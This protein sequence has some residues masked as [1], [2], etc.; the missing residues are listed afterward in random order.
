[1]GFL[2]IPSIF[3]RVYVVVAPVYSAYEGN[4]YGDGSGCT[5]RIG[6]SKVLILGK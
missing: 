3:R 4:I 1:M 5:D 6:A 2:W